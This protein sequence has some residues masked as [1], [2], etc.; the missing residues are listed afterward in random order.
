MPMR[1]TA[2]NAISGTPR[3]APGRASRATPIPSPP[4]PFPSSAAP[5]AASSRSRAVPRRD[6]GDARFVPSGVGLADLVVVGHVDE[7]TVVGE[8]LVIAGGQLLV[9]VVEEEI[10]GISRVGVHDLELR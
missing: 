1:P 2:W 6:R 9:V 10:E 3:E 8:V 7:E 4:N 5:T